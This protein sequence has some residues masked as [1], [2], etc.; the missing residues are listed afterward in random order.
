[1]YENH[2]GLR[3]RPFRPLPD[4]DAYYPATTHEQALHQ[5]LQAV[6]ADEGHMLV[7]GLPGTGKTLLAHCLLE[8]LEPNTTCAFITNSHIP[9]R[10][11][12]LQAVLYELGL[13][14]DQ[15]GEQAL[16][17]TLTDFLL[18]NFK[19]GKRALLLVDEAHHLSPELLE[20]LRLLG[21]LEARQGKAIQVILLAQ[22]AI[23]STL[24]RAEL[25]ALRQRLAVRAV[26]EPLGTDEAADYLLHQIRGAGGR[27]EAVMED[28]ALALIV[29]TAHGVPRVLNQAA[30]Q[31]L[32]LAHAAGQIPVD[33]EAALEALHVLGLSPDEESTE[34]PGLPALNEAPQSA[35]EPADHELVRAL[36]PRGADVARRAAV[37]PRRP[38]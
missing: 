14:H 12:L 19:A 36:S 37:P 25:A 28:E 21:N 17:L 27:P 33:A 29:Q 35:S 18:E 16:R 13:P 7:T 15:P 26:L 8:R 24:A 31:A 23:A 2:F 34:E 38:A 30:H 6:A 5:L 4:C 22:P 11:A 20:E 10:T 32:L 3:R 9:D 1:M